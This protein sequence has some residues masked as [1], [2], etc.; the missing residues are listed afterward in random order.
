MKQVH[1]VIHFKVGGCIFDLDLPHALNLS[2]LRGAEENQRTEQG[3]PTQ[4]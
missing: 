3:K 4:S 2:S 1:V